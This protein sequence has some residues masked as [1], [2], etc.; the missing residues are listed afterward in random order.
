VTRSIGILEEIVD[1]MGNDFT[2][3]VL[4][5]LNHNWILDGAMCQTT[6]PG[7]VEGALIIDWLAPRLAARGVTLE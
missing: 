4:P 3:A 1:R 7:G 5:R 6:G 2:S